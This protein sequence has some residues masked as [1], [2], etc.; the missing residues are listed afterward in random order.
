MARTLSLTLSVTGLDTCT[1]S[2]L[3]VPVH[4]CEV[5]ALPEVNKGVDETEGEGQRN[6]ARGGDSDKTGRA[7][8]GC[9]EDGAEAP[10]PPV[11]TGPA[12]VVGF[13]RLEDLPE[14]GQ[15]AVEG[16]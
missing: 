14:Q 10:L 1:W 8:G 15:H 3:Q 9:R 13:R 6:S 2:D 4:L 12:L 5:C 11:P 16:R 7:G